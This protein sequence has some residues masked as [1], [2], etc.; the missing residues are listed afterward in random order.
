MVLTNGEH[1]LSFDAELSLIRLEIGGAPIKSTLSEQSAIKGTHLISSYCTCGKVKIEGYIKGADESVRR[2]LCQIC[3]LSPS[4]FLVDGA[5]RL[6]LIP[7]YCTE[8]SYEERFKDK[9]LRFT[10]RA[11]SL[12]PYWQASESIRTNYFNC[13]GVSTDENAI[14]QANLGDIATGFLMEI[15][16][17]SSCNFVTLIK[18]EE[19]IEIKRPFKP[20]DK[21]FVDTRHSKKSVTYKIG[22]EGVPI[23]IIEYVHPSSS[24]FELDSGENR[25]D[26]V[27]S[28]GVSYMTLE[29]TPLFLR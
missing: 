29:Y 6:E 24:F 23:N 21:I 15:Y 12:S 19:R 7:E 10:V 5:Y 25:I 20:L 11:L 22:G 4:F 17:M 27:V 26:F 1:S 9:L 8:I 16:V 14:F 28:Q 2:K 18:G 13:G 3:T